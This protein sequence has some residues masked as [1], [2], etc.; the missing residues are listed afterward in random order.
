[1]LSG[2]M[3]QTHHNNMKGVN[4][5]RRRVAK[6]APIAASVSAGAPARPGKARS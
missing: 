2:V 3:Q 1:M 6:T 5:V 4:A